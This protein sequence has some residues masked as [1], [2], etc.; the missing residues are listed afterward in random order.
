MMRRVAKRQNDLILRG[1]WYI[2]RRRADAIELWDGPF[3][4]YKTAK[5]MCQSDIPSG[6]SVEMGIDLDQPLIDKRD[7]KLVDNS[8]L[9]T[10]D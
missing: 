1:H 2:V 4:R 8:D 3:P 9:V 10:K 6:Y 7:A 5:G